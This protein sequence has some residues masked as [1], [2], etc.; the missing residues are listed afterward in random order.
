MKRWSEW[1]PFVSRAEYERAL[2]SYRDTI[3]RIDRDRTE[4]LQIA[5][6]RITEAEARALAAEQRAIDALGQ[7]QTALSNAF[8]LSS[9]AAKSLFPVEPDGDI[10]N[11]PTV[12][13]ADRAAAR[14]RRE[15]EAREAREAA[16]RT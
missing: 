8:A 7:A 15:R 12:G 11:P 6:I 3:Q 4:R 1:W 9:Q 2:D 13:D 10:E 16:E 14:A 5:E